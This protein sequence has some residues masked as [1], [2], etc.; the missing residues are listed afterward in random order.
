MKI[1]DVAGPVARGQG[2]HGGL[3]K[4]DAAGFQGFGFD[5]EEVLGQEHDVFRPLA[6][7]GEMDGEH[8]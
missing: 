5:A 6:K 1:A 8:V 3:G 4:G 2:G 7:R